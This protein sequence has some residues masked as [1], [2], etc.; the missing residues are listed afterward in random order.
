MQDVVGQDLCGQSFVVFS[1]RNSDQNSI[2]TLSQFAQK[3]GLT[4]YTVLSK[5]NASSV[6]IEAHCTD[7]KSIINIRAEANSAQV[8]VNIV[9]GNIRRKKLLLADMDA[10]IIIGESLDEL[11]NLAGIAEK[12]TP[13]TKRAMAGELDFQEALSARLSFLNGQPETLLHQVVKNTQ[14][15]DGAHEVVGTMRAHGA[16]CYLVSGGFTF[17]SGVIAHQLGFTDHHSNIIG[18]SNGMLTGKAVPP[19]LDQQAKLRFL[20]QYIKKF[21]LKPDDCLCVGDG[22]ND[23]AM[24]QHAGMGVAFQ[25]KPTLRKKIELQLNHTD[26]T[27]LL[28][29]QGYHSAEFSTSKPC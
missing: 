23:M 8:D 13:I 18:I 25:G 20:V 10:T 29:L 6:A 4:T 17:L 27:G 7:P 11:A 1:T 2:K 12:I 26:L 5:D 14:I 28:Y 9:S 3:I 22:A 21:N 16:H 19:I 15:T 24:L